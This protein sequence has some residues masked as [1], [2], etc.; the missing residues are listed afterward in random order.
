MNIFLYSYF[1]T[2]SICFGISTFSLRQISKNIFLF[3]LLF[4]SVLVEL[5]TMIFEFRNENHFFLYHFFTPVEYCLLSL[6]C[7]ISLKMKRLKK[8]I[9][10]TLPLFFC[11]SIISLFFDNLVN[12][13]SITNSIESLLLI[14]WS[15]Y[16]LI[17]IEPVIGKPIQSIP[18][19]WIALAI[20]I[21]FTGTFFYNGG[22][23]YLKYYNHKVA[24]SNFNIINSIFN[25]IFYVLMSY[26]LI[27]SYKFKK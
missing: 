4:F 26:G 19:F 16:V 18:E 23:N 9:M 14:I 1:F 21:Y 2:L 8:V 3:L 27:C 24:K 7:L 12:F 25:C 13:P 5:F 20:L 22:Y 11:F 17:T 15:T 10:I 6:Y